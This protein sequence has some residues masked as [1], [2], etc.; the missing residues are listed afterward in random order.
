[1]KLEIITAAAV[2]DI[3][4]QGQFDAA[5]SGK[6]LSLLAQRLMTKRGIMF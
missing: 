4:T 2:S 1:M 6:A 5:F 3:Q